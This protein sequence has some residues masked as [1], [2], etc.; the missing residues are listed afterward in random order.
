MGATGT[1]FDIIGE[2]SLLAVRNF[3]LGGAAALY[4]KVEAANP[5]GSV[6]DRIVRSMI[7][8]AADQGYLVPGT[9]T[10]IEPTSGNTGIG[11]AMAGAALGYNVV[12]TMPESMSLERRKL[13]AAHGA[14][15]VLTPA[16]EGMNGAIVEAERL[17]AETPNAWMPNQFTNPAT[18]RAHYETTG[19]EIAQGLG[20]EAVDYIVAGV[21]TGGTISGTGRYLK[22]LNAAM[23]VVAVE[24]SESPLITQH[25]AGKPLT[26]SG[27]GIQGIGPNFIPKTLDLEVLD[28]V[29]TIS[30]ARA[31]EVTREI[32]AREGLVVGISSGANIAAALEIGARPEA[33][34]KTIVTILPDTGE[35]YFSTPLWGDIS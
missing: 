17:T 25:R 4:A 8:D 29:I 12:L 9:S 35:R 16:A 21:G 15:L 3:D 23:Q 13:L 7:Q 5:G 10:I 22:E 32:S 28:D 18:P 26:P 20:G 14:Q 34:G 27:H 11:L 24:P 1:I 2:T 31:M 19:P 33:A 30:T 6:K